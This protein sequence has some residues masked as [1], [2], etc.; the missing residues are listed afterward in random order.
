MISSPITENKLILSLFWKWSYSWSPSSGNYL[1]R[2]SFARSNYSTY[3]EELFTTLNGDQWTE[4]RD[5]TR[6][7]INQL[8]IVTHSISYSVRRTYSIEN[9]LLMSKCDCSSSQFHVYIDRDY[10]WFY[11]QKKRSREKW[12]MCS[13][14]IAHGTHHHHQSAQKPDIPQ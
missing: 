6:L 11:R 4:K 14:S 13:L 9:A 5:T 8:D 3:K 12:P 1:S 7:S 10:S 2:P